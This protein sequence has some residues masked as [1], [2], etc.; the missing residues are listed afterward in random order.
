MEFRIREATRGD[1]PFLLEMLY[2]ALFVPVGSRPF[3][4]SIIDRPDLARY[5]R[6]FGHQKGDR[7]WIAESSAGNLLGAAWVRQMPADDPGYGFVDEDTPELSIAVVP[8]HRSRGVGTALLGSL[9]ASVPRCSLSVDDRNPAV[10]LYSRCDFEV[11]S[12]EG[13]SLKMLRA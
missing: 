11:V 5:A 3:P 2:E 12:A 8:D 10:S 4:Q 1:E 7:G 9:L 6:G 13:H